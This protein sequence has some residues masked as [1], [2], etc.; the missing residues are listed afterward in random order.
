[1]MRCR[2]RA[3]HRPCGVVPLTAAHR[4]STLGHHGARLTTAW[5]FQPLLQP[6]PT[7]PECI[8][9]RSCLLWCTLTV[10]VVALGPL[11]ALHYLPSANIPCCSHC[12]VFPLSSLFFG[13]DLATGH[14]FAACGQCGV[15]T[16]P[17]LVHG[18]V[19]QGHQWC[20]CCQHSCCLHG[21]GF[22]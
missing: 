11:Q 7:C 17:A 9:G 15:D 6:A 2:V 12:I 22:R 20:F 13:C 1:M 14:V 8:P 4:T 19:V 16:S 18:C 3:Q 10:R 5:T 21:E